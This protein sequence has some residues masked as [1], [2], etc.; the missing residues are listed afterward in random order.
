MRSS[1]IRSR[2]TRA[3]VTLSL[4]A[5]GVLALDEPLPASPKVTVVTS[6]NQPGPNYNALSGVT[7]NSPTD[8]FAVGD[9]LKAGGGYAT[10]IERWDGSAWSIV[11][12]PNPTG[13]SD[14]HLT[15]VTCTSS[16][17]CVAVGNSSPFP[18]G[19]NLAPINT[20]VEQ[21]DGT[22]WQVVPTPRFPLDSAQSFPYRFLTSVTCTSS[23]NCFA[24]GYSTNGGGYR[25]LVLH[26][27]GST[28]TIVPSP[29]RPAPSGGAQV[30][31]SVTCITSTNCFAVGNAHIGNNADTVNRDV[32]LVEHWNG[33]SWKI[34]PS[35]NPVRTGSFL[36][37]VA[38]TA[39]TSCFATGYYAQSDP[40]GRPRTLTLVERWNGTTWKIVPSPTPAADRRRNRLSA[41]ACASS[42]NCLA[43]GSNV[44]AQASNSL[45]EH[46][47]GTQWSI[48]TAPKITGA[49]FLSLDGVACK[50]TVC[51]A[52]GQQFVLHGD[53]TTLVERYS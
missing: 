17:N 3:F 4:V 29:N 40:D 5:S 41:V 8:C 48:V 11:A 46:W 1:P 23:T 7:C 15:A 14:S 25:T 12:S 10:L 31:S 43:V 37:G 20:L 2:G 18:N 16:T 34:V 42:T 52:V 44:L 51:F 21:W 36:Q 22:T 24:V 6:P 53:Y 28:W 9:Y 19:E 35:P 26:W 39:S 38:C 30:L 32:T 50:D 47:N 33:T 49:R 13:E 45:M 27:D